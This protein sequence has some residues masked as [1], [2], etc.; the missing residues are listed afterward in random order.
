MC[1]PAVAQVGLQAAGQVGGYMSQRAAVKARNRAKLLNFRQ[2]NIAYYN[3]AILNDTKW[4]NQQQDTQIAYDNIFQQASE[5]W[6]QQDL[7]IEQAKDKHARYN[8][9]ALQEMYRKEYAGTQT[10]VTA[11][12]LANEPIRKV[13][14]AITK[15][16]RELMMAKDKSILQKEIIRNDA[17]RRRRAAFQKTWR[18]PVHGFTP[19]PPVL[20]ANP[21]PLG[22]MLGIASSAV[23]NFAGGGEVNMYANT[24]P[25]GAHGGA[26]DIRLKEN[27]EEIG[28]SPQGYKIYEF[29]YKG[30][31]VRWRGA[32]AQDI[33]TK[34]P[35]AIG[36]DNG[37]FTVDYNQL[38]ID[39]EVI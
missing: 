9:E 18:S 21:S 24:R 27:I 14:M 38:D 13:G 17:N 19:R 30:D 37:Y 35:Q 15:S 20:E 36:V 39:M 22:M 3:D 12:R 33:I 29:N 32:M 26:S 1:N 31:D 23:G 16:Q 25:P 8:V 11:S 4:K 28:V 5:L 7:A 6:R 10:G 34:L 2:D